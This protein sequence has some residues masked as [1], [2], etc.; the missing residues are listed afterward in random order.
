MRYHFEF[1]VEHGNEFVDL[2]MPTAPQFLDAETYSG[3]CKMWLKRVDIPIDLMLTLTDSLGLFNFFV[4]FDTPAVN[5]YYL[6]TTTAAL[7]AANPSLQM[8]C[9]SSAKFVIPV[10]NETMTVDWLRHRYLGVGTYTI[11]GGAGNLATG[12]TIATTLSS[13]TLD[14]GA[15]AIGR[16]VSYQN[17]IMDDRDC[18]II[19]APWGSRLRASLKS[20]SLRDD[21]A[22]DNGVVASDGVT[23]FEIVIEPLKN[24]AD[25]NTLLN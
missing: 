18:L 13:S 24:E 15:A 8:N 3:R 12:D 25:D 5:R 4:E 10:T 6:S 19:G 23:R 20:G 11:A 16:T 14:T 1:C 21:H 7:L 2:T 9:G 17:D 22:N